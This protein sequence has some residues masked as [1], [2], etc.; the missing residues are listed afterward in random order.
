MKKPRDIVVSHRYHSGPAAGAGGA[1]LAESP[2]PASAGMRRVLAL[3]LVLGGALAA[4]LAALPFA[5]SATAAAG[6]ALYAVAGLVVLDRLPVHHPHP[7]FGLGNGVTL[8]RAAGAAGIAALALEPEVAAG[9]GGWWVAAAVAALLAL[10]AV[11]GWAAR[12][13]GLA[14]AFGARFDMEVDALLVLALAGLALGLGKAGPWVLGLGLMR[15]V[16]VL[17]GLAWPPL[18]RPLPPSRRRSAICG[19]EVATLGL[20]LAPP[21]G[22]PLSAALAAAALAVVTASFA[23]DIRWLVRH[24]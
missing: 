14:S 11:D 5:M 19:F 2:R 4:T 16:F 13:E 17:A 18:A 22:P 7:R 6:L 24:R 15:Y 21:V 20:L 3:V 8:A 9:S 10:D 23:V 1:S 12:R